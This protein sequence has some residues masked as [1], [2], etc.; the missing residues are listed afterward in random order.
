[1]R[2]LIACLVLL[3]CCVVATAGD[4]KKARCQGECAVAVAS[5]ALQKEATVE[6]KEAPLPAQ[7]TAT[8]TTESCSSGTCGASQG[9]GF[10]SPRTRRA[11]RGG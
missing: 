1:M 6:K 3:S 9:T 8:V 5:A 11:R 4:R 10:S 2:F 7:Q